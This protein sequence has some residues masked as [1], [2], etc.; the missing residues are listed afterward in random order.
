MAQIPQYTRGLIKQREVAQ[1]YNP[2]AISNAGLN[3]GQAF[4]QAADW[5]D[6][7]AVAEETT[8]VNEAVIRKQKEDIDF[9]QTKQ[10]EWQNNPTGYA[11]AIDAEMK[12]RNEQYMTTLPSSRAKEAFKQT[13]AR[14][15]LGTYEQAAKWEKTRGVEIIAGRLDNS[16][17]NL[18][19]VSYRAGKEGGSFDD[20]KRNLEATLVAA[21]TV[22]APEKL[23]ELRRTNEKKLTLDYLTGKID[24]DPNGVL[25]DLDSKKYDEMLG[26]DGLEKAYT[27][28]IR[29]KHGNAKMRWELRSKAEKYAVLRTPLSVRNNNPGNIRGANGEFIKFDT[30]EAGRQAMTDD[31]RIKITGRSKA[32]E[33]NFGKGYQPTLQNLI[34]TWAP[35]TEN[36]VGAYVANVTK[37]TGIQAG[38]VLTETDIPKLQEAMTAVEGGAKASN[39]FATG[40]EFDDLPQEEKNAELQKMNDYREAFVAQEAIAG[41][42]L[43]DPASKPQRDELNNYYLST[44][45]ATML[46]NNDVN[47]SIHLSQFAKQ[48]GVIPESAQ[49]ILRG[50]MTSGDAEQ[51]KF[52]YGTIGEIQKIAPSAVTMAGGFTEKEIKDAA[53]FNGLIRSGATAKFANDAVMQASQPM[54]A[55]IRQ[56]RQTE[57]NSLASALKVSTIESVFDESALP[58]TAPDFASAAQRDLVASDYKRIYREAFLQYGDKQ[59]AKDAA[60]AAIK[61]TSGITRV[62]SR[63]SIMKYPPEL[64]YRVDGVDDS[65]MVESFNQQIK[66]DLI[67]LGYDAEIKFT[68]QPTV[69]AETAVNNGRK[70]AYNIWIEGDNGIVDLVRGEDNLPVA[71]AFDQKPLL[72]IKNKQKSDYRKRAQFKQRN[73]ELYEGRNPKRSLTEIVQ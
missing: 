36:D 7:Y 5:A 16:L 62:G 11:K 29:Q 57:V 72:E 15:D 37:M 63:K 31:L 23:D 27:S 43:I 47:A 46:S 24:S 10:T 73:I 21:S 56:L 17:N 8:A 59:M 71:F 39:Y 67:S 65:D 26:A 69:N 51:K 53:V 40:T 61:T 1:V 42:S 4:A 55:D 9:I 58:F 48:Y 3:Y 25:R 41:N 32:M 70:P 33:A 44:E 50:M 60:N 30:P 45:A 22:V 64:Y 19:V 68:L 52:A 54:T 49:G 34:A 6:K 2:Q 38:D 20:V 18:G 35:A 13:A 14:I 12:K 28:A 66:N